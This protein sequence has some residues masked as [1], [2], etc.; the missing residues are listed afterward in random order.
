MSEHIFV[1]ERQ[2]PDPA[3][4]EIFDVFQGVASPIDLTGLPK[5]NPVAG[6]P[7]FLSTQLEVDLP[8]QKEHDEMWEALVLDVCNLVDVLNG[9]DRGEVVEWCRD[10]PVSES[11]SESLSTSI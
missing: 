11:L 9:E 4:G 5:D 10:R 2:P 1:Y 3:T 7:F 6:S 8:S